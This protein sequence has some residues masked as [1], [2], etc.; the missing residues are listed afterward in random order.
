MIY[1][2]PTKRIAAFC[3][4]V[5]LILSFIYL[6]SRVVWMIVPEFTVPHHSMVL[7][8]AKQRW[9]Y[10]VTT[11]ISAVFIIFYH[12]VLPLYPRR[13]TAG[14]YAMGILLLRP[15]GGP[16]TWKE[17]LRRFVILALKMFCL[18]FIGPLLA[19]QFSNSALALSGLLFPI[20][21]NLVI[22]A[23]AQR[24]PE[25]AFLWE[26]LGNYRYVQNALSE[27]PI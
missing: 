3:L 23:I 10:F 22:C 25:G 21:V 12:C 4:D 27:A 2:K 24:R 11:F 26:R 7:F 18:F 14:Q 6:T 13:C 16:L 15:D 17:A 8:S 19:V 5:L 9:V 20:F 1:A